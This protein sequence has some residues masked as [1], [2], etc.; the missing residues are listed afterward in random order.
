MAPL[1]VR[2]CLGR[3]R[4]K[5]KP[6]V[7]MIAVIIVDSQILAT[8]TSFTLGS[9]RFRRVSQR[10]TLLWENLRDPYVAFSVQRSTT[11][12]AV[13]FFTTARTALASSAPT[14]ANGC[15]AP[16]PLTISIAHPRTARS[17]STEGNDVSVRNSR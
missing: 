15:H 4:T 8:N 7:V 1:D 9:V 2:T 3:Q 12:N 17:N 13:P 16:L 10:A 14:R 11:T 5:K 6:F